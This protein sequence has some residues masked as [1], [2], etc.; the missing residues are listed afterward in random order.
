MTLT[1]P[2]FVA[3]CYSL[4]HGEALGT[5]YKTWNGQGHGIYEKYKVD[6]TKGLHNWDCIARIENDIK[7]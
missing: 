1:I 6:A 3:I 7:T 2:S 4:P 5:N